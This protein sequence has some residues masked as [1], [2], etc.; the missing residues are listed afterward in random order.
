MNLRKITF[1]AAYHP[2]RRE[3]L[4]ARQF[5]FQIEQQAKRPFLKGTVLVK[6]TGHYVRRV[7]SGRKKP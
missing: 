2:E 7:D 3:I 1:W 6:L 5:K 4:S